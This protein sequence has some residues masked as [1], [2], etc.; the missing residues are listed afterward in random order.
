VTAPVLSSAQPDGQPQPA[1]SGTARTTGAA[2]PAPGPAADEGLARRLR[3]LACTAPLH[4]LDTR[5]AN[6][7]GE[8]GV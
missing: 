7:A 6:L 1:A 4:D 5:K 8:Y 3:A 2:R